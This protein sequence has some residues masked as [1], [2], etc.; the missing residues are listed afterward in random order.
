MKK[1]DFYPI[2][3]RGRIAYGILCMENYLAMKYPNTD[4]SH[5]LEKAWSIVSSENIDERAYEFMEIIPEYLFEF[6][7]YTDAGYEYLSEQEYDIFIEIIPR[8]DE[9]LNLIMHRIYDIAMNNAYAGFT[10]PAKETVALLFDIIDALKNAGIQ[11]PDIKSVSNCDYS[12]YN[13]WGDFVSPLGLST[14][15]TS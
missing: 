15:I 14:V 3:I 1:S 11:L 2:S 6:D 5:M 9:T 8:S 7:N 12:T 10:A 13:G 4:F